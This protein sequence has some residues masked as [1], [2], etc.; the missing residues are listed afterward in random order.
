MLEKYL[1]SIGLSDKESVV[2][3]SLV[4]VDNASV[5]DLSKRTKLKRPTVYVILESLAKKGLVSE[6]TVGKKTHYQAEPPERL[7]T[8]VERQ[9]LV[10][11]E[12]SKRLKDI[13]PEIKSIQRE[14][15]ERPVV[16]YF[17]GREGIIGSSEELLRD[18]SDTSKEMYMIYPKDILEELFSESEL[19][20]LRK[21][22]ID[23]GIKTKVLY[24]S[25]KGE[26]PSD[27]TGDRIKIEHE[28]YPIKCDISVYSDKVRIGIL[29]KRLSSIFIRSK[30]FADTIRSF[31]DLIFDKNK[32]Q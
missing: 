30:D 2:Y 19:S 8:F 32:N 29:G 16:K 14:S 22:R 17:E 13:I 18:K 26:R 5:L 15:G 10:L 11:D 27:N 3:L 25:L 21:I 20:G 24:T 28:K 4:Q 23:R 9:K 12:S 6:T 31:V 7:E 1:Q